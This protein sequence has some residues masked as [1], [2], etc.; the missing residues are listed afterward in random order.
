MVIIFSDITIMVI[1]CFVLHVF[2]MSCAGLLHS[3]NLVAD[4]TTVVIYHMLYM[5][6]S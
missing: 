4:I 1:V 3:L 6:A 5:H 2:S